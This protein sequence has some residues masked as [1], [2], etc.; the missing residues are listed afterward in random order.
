ME[1]TSRDRPSIESYQT[2]WSSSET[3]PTTSIHVAPQK[4][5][6]EFVNWCEQDFRPQ[7]ASRG[8]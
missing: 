8:K 7:L 2:F 1:L 3:T 4:A 5:Y 6:E